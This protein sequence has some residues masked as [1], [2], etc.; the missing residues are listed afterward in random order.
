VV[1]DDPTIRRVMERVLSARGLEVVLAENGVRAKALF[2]ESRFDL[3]LTDVH[4]PK[5]DG[6]GVL[7]AVREVDPDFPVI[8]FTAAPS[9]DTAIGA[10]QLHA[11]AY[12]TKPIEPA[13]LI[14]EVEKALRLTELARVR[15]Q[16]HEVILA[17]AQ[18]EATRAA[19][20]S[21]FDRALEGLFMVY[22]PIVSWSRRSVFGYEALV[23]SKEPSLPHPGALFEAAE[24]LS[25]WDD[26][27]RSI[28][29][30]CVEPIA[31]IDPGI[32]LFVNLH[33]RELLDDTL[34]DEDSP[35]ARVSARVVLEITERA[36][37][38]T[39]ADAEPRIARLRA[40]GFRIAIDDIGAGYSGLNSFAMLRPD[41]VKLDMALVR[42]IDKD[43]V[44]RRLA[45]LLVQLCGDLGI[46]VVGEGVET[47]T[48]RQALAELGC[49]LLQGY[50]FGRPS[51]T[52][53]VP[54]LGE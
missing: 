9:A 45:G 10:L 31:Q 8:L 47:A 29:R 53:L 26:L 1:D 16:A 35:L 44:K 30:K 5:M 49:D 39:V 38:E 42:D 50:L 27:G 36:H 40:M 34:F 32:S 13:K 33:A 41:L 18:E 25:R 48:E 3:V 4:M 28:R 2:S 43:P 17:A 21:Q 12:L 24:R 6:I 14:E 54:N 52:L 15:K 46:A 11:T 23:R 22:Q 51:P 37:I 19:A 7:R 20:I